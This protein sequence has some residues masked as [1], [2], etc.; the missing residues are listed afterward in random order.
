MVL[1][2]FRVIENLII[3]KKESFFQVPKLPFIILLS[4][5]IGNGLMAQDWKLTPENIEQAFEKQ[6]SLLHADSLHPAYHLTP[7]A[8]GMGDPNG[9]IYYKGWYHIFYG[10]QPF[11]SALGGWF[12][13][14]ARSR[15]LLHWEHLRPGLTPA[16][17]LGL[18]HVGSGSTIRTENGQVLAF[19][20]SSD[21]DA[22]KFWRATFNDE[23][24]GWNHEG[25]NP[26]LTLDQPGLPAF[27]NFWRD[28]FVF[29]TAGRTFMIA[30]AD[31]LDQ[32]YVPVPIFEALN[33]ELTN[34]EYKGI[35]F[36]WPKHQ[37]R[38]LEVPELRP[39]GD[40]WIFMASGD[41][42]VDRTHYFLG[43]LDL[44]KLKFYPR[45]EGV[46]DYSGHYYAQ[47]S[48][49]DDTGNLYVMAWMPGWDRPW[50]PDFRDEDLKNR[51]DIWN[52]CFALPRKL[53][54]D[55]DGELIQRPAESL[56]QLRMEHFYLGQKD[57][58]VYGPEAAYQVLEIRG[59][60]L[61]M[62]LELDLG[63]ASFCGL[64]VLCNDNGRGGLYIIWSG[65]VLNVEGVRVPIR[66]WE[67]GKPLQLQIFIDKQLVEVFAGG[68][69][70]CI[71]RMVKPGN[72]KGDHIALTTLGGH[73]K[74]NFL[75]AWPLKSLR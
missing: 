25:K 61:E 38:N 23:L 3:M 24:T 1:P 42:P 60:Q 17:E 68:G 48:I 26:V 53:S 10:L 66:E 7:P 41:A 6:E 45:K 46:L 32:D 18:D 49:L 52:G 11:S 44:D 16:F 43:D 35:L 63:A 57:L 27:D 8:G 30:C 31:L 29:S 37:L 73:A 9:G 58:P 12:W 22:M 54:L 13:A 62:N 65:E 51:S 20:S 14:H 56:R 4:S 36:T 15:D 47:E 75:E 59:N 67:K 2:A 72:I 55:N 19:Y 5:I 69:R 71:S 64:N 33:E 39:L 50:L 74:L 28:P 70:Y 21:G 40:Q 34:W